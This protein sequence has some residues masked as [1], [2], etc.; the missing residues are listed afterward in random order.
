MGL[1]IDCAELDFVKFESVKIFI[2]G[3]DII[4]DNC[5]S[6]CALMLTSCK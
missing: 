5:I 3:L 4:E 2:V 1:S 6:S